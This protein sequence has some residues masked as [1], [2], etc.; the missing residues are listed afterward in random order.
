MKFPESAVFTTSV[1]ECKPDLKTGGLYLLERNIILLAEEG[2]KT[3][4]LH[5]TGDEIIFFERKIKHRVMKRFPD[6]TIEQQTPAKAQSVTAPMNIFFQKHRL[7][8]EDTFERTA[9]GNLTFLQSE[10]VFEVHSPEDIKKAEKLLTSKIIADT[11]GVIARNINKRISIPLSLLICKTRIHPNILTLFNFLI[12]IIKTQFP[13]SHYEEYVPI[14]KK[15]C[16][17]SKSH[18]HHG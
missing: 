5:L 10:T 4:H 15:K 6:L 16:N 11:G 17:F 8:Q 2:V 12:G 13:E 9:D 14:A 3:I 18:C 7:Q 1:A